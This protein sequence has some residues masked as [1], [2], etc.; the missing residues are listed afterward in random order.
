MSA[1]IPGARHFFCNIPS[2]VSRTY[3]DATPP[4]PLP[5]AAAVAAPA[6]PPPPLPLPPQYRRRRRFRPRRRRRHRFRPRA[7]WAGTADRCRFRPAPPSADAETARRHRDLHAALPP[8]PL[9]PP[10]PPL[11]VAAWPG[12]RE[13]PHARQRAEPTASKS[14]RTHDAVARHRSRVAIKFVPTEFFALRPMG[15]PTVTSPRSMKGRQA[16]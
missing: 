15:S 11:A 14:L 9:H 7:A 13:A 6:P 12:Q 1:A 3:L 16:W 2:N 5:R 8:A 10:R 4:P